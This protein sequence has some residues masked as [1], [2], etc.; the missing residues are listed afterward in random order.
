M[1]LLGLGVGRGGKRL[2]EGGAGSTIGV[3]IVDCEGGESECG[4]KSK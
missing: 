1:G 2:G 3:E 4:T